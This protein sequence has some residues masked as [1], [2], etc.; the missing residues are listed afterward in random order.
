MDNSSNNNT[1]FDEPESFY[2]ALAADLLTAKDLV[3][4]ASPFVSIERLQ[5][6]KRALKCCIERGVQICVFVQEPPTEYGEDEHEKKNARLEAAISLLRRWKIH[7][8]VQPKIHA[9]FVTIDAD[10]CYEGSLNPLSHNNTKERMRRVV[11]NAEV[12][13]AIKAHGLGQ[14]AECIARRGAGLSLPGA[15]TEREQ[16]EML[17]QAIYARRKQLKLSQKQLAH[18]ANLSQSQISVIEKASQNVTLS[19][20]LAACRALGLDLQAVHWSEGPPI[21]HRQ[22]DN[23]QINFEPANVGTQSSRKEIRNSESFRSTQQ[24][25]VI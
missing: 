8:T 1:I 12:E 13:Q 15:L 6:L 7:V 23:S 9:K 20:V 4:I 14:C 19:L 22:K 17:G 18:L 25:K 5:S 24:S 3:L 21:S 10:V 16:R 2:S 11:G